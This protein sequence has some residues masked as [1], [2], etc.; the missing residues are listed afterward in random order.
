[1]EV[2]GFYGRTARTIRSIGVC[3]CGGLDHDDFMGSLVVGNSPTPTAEIRRC[4]K[5]N[6]GRSS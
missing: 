4:G 2:F 1:M 5:T 6:G 3:L